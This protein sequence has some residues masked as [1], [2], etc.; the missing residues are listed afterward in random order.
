MFIIDRDFAG[1]QIRGDRPYQ[2]DFQGFGDLDGGD[3]EEVSL[4]LTVLADGMGGENAGDVASRVAVREFIHFCYQ[5]FSSDTASIP[6]LLKEATLFAN[7]RLAELIQENPELAGM[8]TTLL[9]TVSTNKHLYWVSVGDSPLFHY[10]DKRL[11]KLNADHSMMPLL[12]KEVERG[13]LSPDDL[14]THP[15][16]NVLRSALTGDPIELIDCPAEGLELSGGDLLIVASD[17]LDTLS[18]EEI[19]ERMERHH[20]LP[21]D[22]I[23]DKLPVAVVKAQKPRQDNTSINVICVKDMDRGLADSF[24]DEGKT[25][26]IRTPRYRVSGSE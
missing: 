24:S 23:V 7:Q 21:A 26:L 5:H 8:G 10:R 12:I 16:R 9:A 17:G 4:L 19:R 25:V 1:R 13:N 3:G 22:G 20:T 6:Q 14:G 18:E 11:T 15:D 2:Q